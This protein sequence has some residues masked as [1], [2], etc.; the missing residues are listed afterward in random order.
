[1]RISLRPS[2]LPSGVVSNDSSPTDA[3]QS[4]AGDTRKKREK[5]IPQLTFEGKL[6]LIELQAG[7]GADMILSATTDEKESLIV[8]RRCYQLLIDG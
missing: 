2:S 3:T 1:V 7:G 4:T 6:A 5:L 8:T